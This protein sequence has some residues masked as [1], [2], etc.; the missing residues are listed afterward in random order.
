M[1]DLRRRFRGEVEPRNGSPSGNRWSW[2]VR[3][4]AT[5]PRKALASSRVLPSHGPEPGTRSGDRS[6]SI[7]ETGYT[8]DVRRFPERP[9]TTCVRTPRHTGRRA[10]RWTQERNRVATE[11]TEPPTTLEM[12]DG[13]THL[14]ARHPGAGPRG[15]VRLTRPARRARD[16]RTHR[17]MGPDPERRY[18][19]GLGR[20]GGARRDE[21][22]AVRRPGLQ[23]P[24]ARLRLPCRSVSR[25]AGAV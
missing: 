8:G 25:T 4:R 7:D 11:R 20:P 17:A 10:R 21:G 2:S 5:R 1:I 19:K 9:G 23:L 3:R 22:R 13:R 6:S 14:R 12:T 15:G 24:A 16:R 18:G